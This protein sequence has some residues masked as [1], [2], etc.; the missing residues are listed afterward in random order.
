MNKGHRYPP[1]R[2]REDALKELALQDG[3][4]DTDLL[5]NGLEDRGR[6]RGEM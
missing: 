6:G 1:L 3:N 5:K 4:K 2:Q